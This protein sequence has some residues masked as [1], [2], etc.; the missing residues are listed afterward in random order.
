MNN[1]IYEVDRED[2]RNFIEQLNKDMMDIEEYA[3]QNCYFTK[4]ISKKTNKHLSSRISDSDL[5]EEHYFIFNY[6]DDDERIAPKPVL[7][8]NL[9]TRK[10]VQDFLNALSKIQ[11]E[12]NHG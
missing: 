6:P 2:Y 8:I 11:K 4:V 3:Y 9:D 5:E 12:N 7:K 10:E 1:S